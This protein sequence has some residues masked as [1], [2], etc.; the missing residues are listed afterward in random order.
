MNRRYL[1]ANF[2]ILMTIRQIDFSLHQRFAQQLQAV[3]RDGSVGIAGSRL[4]LRRQAE[5][6]HRNEKS[7]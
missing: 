7:V 5:C 6:L 1:P 2:D 3:L 4:T